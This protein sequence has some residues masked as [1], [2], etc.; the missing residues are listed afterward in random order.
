MVYSD[1]PFNSSKGKTLLKD[2]FNLMFV[3]REGQPSKVEQ[4][5]NQRQV[6]HYKGNIVNIVNKMRKFVKGYQQVTLAESNSSGIHV[7]P[8]CRRRDA[9]WMW[10]TVDAGHYASPADWV[11]SVKP[12][13]WKS[14]TADE[15]E[16]YQFVVRYRCND[17]TTCNKC[18]IT[19]AGHGNSTCSNRVTRM[20]DG[21]EVSQIC[22]SSDLSKVGCG[23]ESFAT[24]FIREYTADNNHPQS[25]TE[26]NAINN[27]TIRDPNNRR[28]IITLNGKLSGYRFEHKQAP[29]G[30][31]IDS[32][33]KIKEYLPSIVFI[34]KDT[35]T[36]YTS[37][38]SYP[39]SELNYAVSK[40]N[41]VVCDGGIQL[42]GQ[43]MVAH[44]YSRPQLATSQNDPLEACPVKNCKATDYPP[45]KDV[46]GVYYRPIPMRIMN[47]Q[48]LSISG[49][50]GGTYKQQPVYDIYLESPVAN[51]FKLLLPLAQHMSLRPIPTE[52]QIGEFSSGSAACPNDVGGE[53]AEQELIN[54]ANEKLKEEFQ[55]KMDDELKESVND[56]GGADGQ[57]NI[58]FTFD[59][60][61]GRSR[62]AYYDDGIHKWIDDSPPCKSY[63]KDGKTLKT[64]REYPRWSEI[65]SYSPKALADTYF[66]EYLGPDPKTHLLMD[67]IKCNQQLGV[68]VDSAPN[69]HTV[70][71]IA[72]RIDENVGVIYTV[73]ECRTC[74]EIVKLGGV[75]NWRESLGDCDATGTAIDGFPQGV[76]DTEIAYEKS[77]P[78]VDTKGNPVPTAWGING[79]QGHEGKKMLENPDLNIRIG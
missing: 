26:A 3:G 38:S 4:G 23:E 65:P 76:L 61:E 41:M 9:I 15:N 54:K 58:G 44:P 45:L 75:I 39:V 52:P 68:F 37:E 63:R 29:K 11:S 57:T 25:F 67:W 48:P 2:I 21:D 69:Y 1:N 51:S 79:G 6:S 72:D 33:D 32:W 14:G 5:D 47:A 74:R 18:H 42:R 71:Q 22:G 66:T 35:P 19:V 7:C 73:F 10:E 30:K 60:C 55:K 24:H 20:V 46:R 78:T 16:R 17:V 13:K 27:K 36:G 40:Q 59:V 70:E 77:Y 34:Y 8:H 62:S 43:T 50:N 53:V 12:I 28:N 64:V 56:M 49:I 31:I